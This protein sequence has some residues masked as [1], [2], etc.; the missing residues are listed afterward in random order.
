MVM[1]EIN[2]VLKKTAFRILMVVVFVW[3]IYN[4]WFSIT[5]WLLPQLV[6]SD[7]Q[8]DWPPKLLALAVMLTIIIALVVAVRTAMG[9]WWTLA[10][11][12]ITTLIT[13]IPF[14]YDWLPMERKYI[15]YAGYFF[16]LP[17]IFGL[18]LSAGYWSRWW[19]GIP[20]QTVVG[21]HIHTTATD[22]NT[23]PASDGHHAG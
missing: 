3:L 22:H 1:Q 9:I 17:T 19:K 13:I 20:M 5:T 8:S 14:Y 4:P 12:T 23:A 11:L 21:G 10:V 18:A 6:N 7:W 16:I 2:F 15:L